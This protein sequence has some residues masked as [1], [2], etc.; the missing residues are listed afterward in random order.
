MDAISGMA[1]GNH[2]CQIGACL[3]WTITEGSIVVGAVGP[4]D[5]EE[6]SNV[7]C[8]WLMVLGLKTGDDA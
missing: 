1:Q 8:L 2:P 6:V 7:S 3:V 4:D 5:E